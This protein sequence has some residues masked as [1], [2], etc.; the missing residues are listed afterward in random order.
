MVDLIILVCLIIKEI[1][2]CSLF[3]QC[4]CWSPTYKAVLTYLNPHVVM[5]HGAWCLWMIIPV[6][7]PLQCC[8]K[9]NING[10]SL[11]EW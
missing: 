7:H 1:A 5:V 10:M 2:H 4:N 9:L 6:Y 11:W 3:L 8:F